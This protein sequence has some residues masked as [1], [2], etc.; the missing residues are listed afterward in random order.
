[1][2]SFGYRGGAYP[3]GVGTQEEVGGA[4]GGPVRGVQP[5]GTYLANLNFL[6]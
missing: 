5:L 4:I 3:E 2:L 1:M 6:I